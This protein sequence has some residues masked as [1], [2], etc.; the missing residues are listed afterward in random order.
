MKCKNGHGYDVGG[1]SRGFW[2]LLSQNSPG[3]TEDNEKVS[4]YG[5]ISSQNVLLMK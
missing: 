1:G 2:R 5:L 3:Y 4:Q